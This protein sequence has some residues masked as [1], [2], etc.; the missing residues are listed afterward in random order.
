MRDRSEVARRPRTLRRTTLLAAA[1]P[2]AG[3][4]LIGG[5][6][7]AG[8]A[9]AQGPGVSAPGAAGGS[10][11]AQRETARQR[12]APAP[13][14]AG[15]PAVRLPV[16]DED[17]WI[18]HV[19]NRLGYGPRPGD[20]E[21]VRRM[22]LANYIALQLDPERIP[23]PVVAAKLQPL[24]TLT[25]R[26]QDLFA[27]YPQPTPEERRA[28]QEEPR[29]DERLP[30]GGAAAPGEQ[31]VR[32]R[33]LAQMD[34]LGPAREGGE[35]MEGAG[36]PEPGR[37][38]APEGRGAMMN[39]GPRDPAAILAR[40]ENRPAAIIMEL[41]QAKVLRAIYSERQLQEVMADF[42]YNH[43]NVFAPKGADKWLVTSYD[44]DVIRR[45]ALGRFRDLLGATAR[46]P[47]MLFYLDNWM[48]SKEGGPT[49]FPARADTQGNRRRPTG[50]NE[51]YARELLE[52]HT[53]GVDGGYSQRDV[54]EVARCFTGW[55]LERPERGGGFV[56]RRQMHDDGEKV[57]LGAR[58]PAGG[59]MRD[60]EIVLDLLARH[61]STATFIATKLARRFVSDTPPPALVD[62]AARVFRGT[63][64]DI[65]A[66]VEAIVTSPEF[67]SEEAYRAKIKKPLEVVASA[68]RVLGS[69]A[70]SLSLL[71]MAVGRIGEPLFQMQPPTGYPD[72]GEAWVNTGALLN[73]MNF[74]LAL[75]AGRIPG[76]RV[77]LD[78]LIGP[79]DRRHPE[80]VMDRLLAR[81]LGGDVSE[82]TRRTLA[83]QLNDPQITRATQDDRE[84]GADLAKLAA[85]ILGSPEF[86]RR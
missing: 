3:A 37:R 24:R 13:A 49:G 23:D 2:W 41:A 81:I 63:D 14:V 56:Y 77:D 85:L 83:A 50:L 25:M 12:P 74:A 84:A 66:V 53:L 20:V 9:V 70:Q 29:R 67:F 80:Q 44:R 55:S 5:C 69:E 82:D 51:N 60:G 30:G 40:M 33:T 45:H 59:G 4:L 62:R 42:W 68:V 31:P 16:P 32:P 27:A 28:R 71:P 15:T 38:P 48:S 36:R 52:L 19:L 43:F 57:V 26:T 22:G 1:L 35:P 72:K 76:A 34:P 61:P 86:Q 54:T 21:R 7:G 11:F 17:K 73:R 58:I 75:A 65:R 6:V 46:H 18:V 8:Q 78:Q 39:D 79:V 47:A 64:G 10:P